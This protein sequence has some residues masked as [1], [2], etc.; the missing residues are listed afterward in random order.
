MNIIAKNRQ[1]EWKR[2]TYV[3]SVAGSFVNIPLP[4][5]FYIKTVYVQPGTNALITTPFQIGFDSLIAGNFPIADWIPAGIGAI[6]NQIYVRGGS[7]GIMM[8]FSVERTAETIIS[9]LG[10][11][12]NFYYVTIEYTDQVN[13]YLRKF[14]RRKNPY[15]R[16]DGRG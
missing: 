11:G 12:G 13:K 6:Y 3:H 8:T 14:P 7:L 15:P 4:Y 5:T 10:S 16:G 9:Y 1:I 2:F